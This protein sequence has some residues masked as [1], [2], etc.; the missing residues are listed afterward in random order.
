MKI[1]FALAAL[2]TWVAMFGA[3]M[4][5]ADDYLNA[6]VQSLQSGR[7][8]VSPEVRG[9]DKAALEQAVG[10]ND[11]AI[12]VM[13]AT[14]GSNNGGSSGFLTSLAAQ[15]NHDTFIVV[16]GSDL[17]AASR[18][19]PSGVAS[20]LANKAEA[21]NATVSEALAATVR[22]IKAQK[23]T[24]GTVQPPPQGESSN[25]APFIGGGI[26]LV[27]L[28]IIGIVIARRFL[29]SGNR[30]NTAAIRFKL[31]PA[32]VR[33]RT[34]AVLELRSRIEDPQLVQ[35]LTNTGRHIEAYFKNA[36]TQ[37]DGTYKSTDTIRENVDRLQVVVNRYIMVQD[38]P[39]YYRDATTRQAEYKSA[40][41]AFERFMLEQVRSAN[42]DEEFDFR[43]AAEILA[44]T[45]LRQIRSS[46]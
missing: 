44:A 28:V 30:V 41:L 46:E 3:P 9:V 32:I 21:N 4:A 20:Q 34:Q 5:Y 39:L 25:P 38:E 36:K 22:D 13:P 18:V 16:V 19:L 43:K 27:L 35:S 40:A 6:A 23:T 14:A 17:E 33:E 12:V 24:T 42:A 11:I 15:S 26:G 10:N 1:R 31:T 37:A 2:F 8:Y 7:I 29:G 45:E